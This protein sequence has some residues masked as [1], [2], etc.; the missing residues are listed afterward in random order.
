VLRLNLI[1]IL[2]SIPQSSKEIGETFKNWF[3]SKYEKF[4]VEIRNLGKLSEFP[5]IAGN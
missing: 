4:T 5:N 3:I 1:S 2:I